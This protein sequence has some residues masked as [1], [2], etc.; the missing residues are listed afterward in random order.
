MSITPSHM[1]E[2]LYCARYTW[3]EYVLC[4]PQ[5][6]EKYYKVMKGRHLHDAKLEQ[7]KD[8]LRRRI[9]V[10][11]KYQNRYL[12]NELLRGEVDEVLLLNDGSMAPLDYKF[13]EYDERIFSTYETQ[14]NCY[15][16]LI[17]ANYGKPVNRGYLVFTRSKNRLVEVA[18]TEASKAGVTD[19]AKAII[20]IID[21]NFYPR[22]SRNEK[23]CVTCTYRNICTQ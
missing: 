14:L 6:E 16:V 7:N 8:Y 18:I 4:I 23:K 15:A 3:F 19:C 22:V 21:N 9:G 11:E 1:I 12:T 2:Y 5:N 13:A 20:N 17:E 10:K